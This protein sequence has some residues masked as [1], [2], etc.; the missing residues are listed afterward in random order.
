M[1]EN[2]QVKMNK[3]MQMKYAKYAKIC[4]PMQRPLEYISIAYAKTNDKICMKHANY[5]YAKI[6]PPPPPHLHFADA[7]DA[8]HCQCQ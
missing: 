7:M 4:I 2:A 1:L 3:N 6:R 8:R 5:K